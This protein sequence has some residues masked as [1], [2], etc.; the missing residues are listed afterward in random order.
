MREFWRKTATPGH[1]LGTSE[2]RRSQEINVNNM[3]HGTLRTEKKMN[4][5]FKIWITLTLF[6][7]IIDSFL[8]NGAMYDPNFFDFSG[9]LSIE[10]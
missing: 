7:L 1:G 2:E 5:K 10:H 6:H 3:I 9:N 8:N 4:S